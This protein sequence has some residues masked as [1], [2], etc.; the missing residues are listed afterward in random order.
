MDDITSWALSNK[1]KWT[2]DQGAK[3]YRMRIDYEDPTTPSRVRDIK[4]SI[5]SKHV[6]DLFDE[7]LRGDFLDVILESGFAKYP[8][9]YATTSVNHVHVRCVVDAKDASATVPRWWVA[10]TTSAGHSARHRTDS[11]EPKVMISFGFLLEKTRVPDV[12]TPLFCHDDVEPREAEIIF[13][14]ASGVCRFDAESGS[15]EIL[16]N[17]D[18]TFGLAF[19]GDDR[20]FFFKQSRDQVG[21][22][23]AD[24]ALTGEICSVSAKDDNNSPA[25][26]E[27]VGLDR[28]THQ[29]R[30]RGN[31]L[32]VQET[33]LQ[34]FRRY[35]I[36]P[37]TGS[38][39]EESMTLLNFL[40][41]A[42]HA[43]LVENLFP[44]Y[45][46][47]LPSYLHN[48]AFLLEDD[49]RILVNCSFLRNWIDP[50]TKKAT[51]NPVPTLS[52]VREYH[53]SSGKLLN[54]YCLKELYVH[55]LEFF[56]DD[57]TKFAFMSASCQVCFYDTVS[58]NVF[59]RV[60]LSNASRGTG[61]VG[62][63]L[64]M[65]PCGKCCLAGTGHVIT[66]RKSNT[67]ASDHRNLLHLV[68][69][70]SFREVHVWD[71][72]TDV[73]CL[74]VRGETCPFHQICAPM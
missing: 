48:N 16:C 45:T 19:Y 54:T 62:R 8:I 38:V 65:L 40:P 41:E 6:G 21:T 70:T 28:N 32:Y 72:Q 22:T 51:N 7:P 31:F 4:S 60:Q 68:D 64:F 30:I 34:R 1:S 33:G 10:G 56:V 35:E 20:L 44:E 37:A 3:H 27:I 18:F 71:I 59:A 17:G 67:V 58:K 39:I 52:E 24:A 5:K 49:D 43:A 53:V 23:D 29:L 12:C 26:T 42:R 61:L 15:R 50:V 46:D 2:T 47:R 9:D 74:V 13:T 63:G 11:G 57:R 69:L 66:R 73:R 14:D 55:D 36:S 25:K